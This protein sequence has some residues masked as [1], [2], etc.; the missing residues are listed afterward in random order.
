MIVLRANPIW[1]SDLAGIDRERRVLQIAVAI[2]AIVPITGG[3]LGIV[4][5]PALTQTPTFG[6]PDSRYRYQSGL[7]IEIGLCFWRL[8]PSI[9]KRTMLYRALAFILVIGGIEQ[10]TGVIVPSNRP[11]PMLNVDAYMLLLVTQ[12]F[13]LVS[14]VHYFINPVAHG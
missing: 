9:E 6:S 3:L 12:S 7:L 5:G 13:L 11:T 10:L 4:I 8:I 2:A 1:A 14:S